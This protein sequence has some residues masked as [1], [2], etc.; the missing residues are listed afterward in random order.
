[1][2]QTKENN[3]TEKR[4]KKKSA[5]AAVL[6]FAVLTIITYIQF[7]CAERAEAKIAMWCYFKVNDYPISPFSVL[8]VVKFTVMSYLVSQNQSSVG[9]CR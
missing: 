4:E 3:A 7:D 8:V 9:T 6:L 5:Y 1:M 2:C